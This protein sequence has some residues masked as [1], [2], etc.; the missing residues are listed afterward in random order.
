MADLDRETQARV[1]DGY[2]SAYEDAV[3]KSI[4]ISG[5]NVAYFAD[6]K[7]KLMARL[8][9]P[10]SMNAVLDFGCGTGLFT[11]AMS[12]AL[13]DGVEFTGIDP[14]EASIDVA[15][16]QATPRC[17]FFTLPEDS[18]P[19]PDS[20]FSD[21]AAANVFHHIERPEHSRWLREIARV[22]KPGGTLWVFEHNPRNPLTR[23][24]VRECPFDEGVILLPPGYLAQAMAAANL[25][26]AEAYYY[27]YFPR[28]LSLFRGVEPLLSG[29]P[30]G[31]QFLMRGTKAR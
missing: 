3:D 24:S 6:L 29:V 8:G 18:L 22:L 15:R 28:A 7:A 27:F 30:F 25:Q 16:S 14:S 4:V 11:R 23:R 5:E 9:E 1:F 26:P 13:A 31:A 20:S 21:V 19:F 10:R 2:A 17:E 12:G